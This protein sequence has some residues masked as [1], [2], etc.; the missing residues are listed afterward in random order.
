MSIGEIPLSKSAL[1]EAILEG[2]PASTQ[3]HRCD[4]YFVP[5]GKRAEVLEA[6]GRMPLAAAFRFL[7]VISSL[8]LRSD[9]SQ[10]PF[11]PLF[12]MRGARSAVLDEISDEQIAVVDE[13]AS[14]VSDPE[15]RARLA[16]I[17][18]I[19]KRN[20]Q[21][22][23]T[24][25]SAY[26]DSGKRILADPYESHA[27]VR[28]ERALQ[29]AAELGKQQSP[30]ES[31][32]QVVEEIASSTDHHDLIISRCLDLTLQYG[33]RDSEKFAQIAESR[34]TSPNASDKPIWQRRFWELGA[35]FY[36]RAGKKDDANRSRIEIA[37]TF[38]I[39]AAQAIKRESSPAY[40]VAATFLQNAI[41]AYRQVPGTEG[42]RERVHLTLLEY[43]MKAIKEIPTFRSGPVDMSDTAEHA[44]KMVRGKPLTVA[45]RILALSGETIHVAKLRADAEEEIDRCPL[46]FLF[47]A[48]TMSGTGKVVAKQGTMSSTSDEDRESLVLRQM[49]WHASHIH[50][51]LTV[52]GQIEPMRY[53]ILDEQFVRYED[54]LPFVAYNPLIPAGREHFY[55]YGLHAGLHGR[56]FEALH[57]LI[58]QFENSVR[59]LLS[60]HGII[61]SSL[62]ARGLQKEFDLNA[63]LYEPK[64][65][66]LFGEDTVFE[67]RGL[68]VEQASSNFRNQLAHGMLEYGAFFTETAVYIWWLILRLCVLGTLPPPVTDRSAG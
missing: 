66:E 4:E 24:A 58:P 50:R 62:D 28:F 51:P 54:F 14:D 8:R 36:G 17:V 42:E 40:L 3:Q 61:A 68:L 64:L 53:Q 21:L 47:P 11:E 43:Q 12:A 6:D 39:E 37:K 30:F 33:K 52:V 29:I 55:L 45:L 31:A 26:L 46:A 38:E 25:V 13:C 19:R 10:Q 15:L 5:F 18:W 59:C 20:H 44:K 22:A 48:S 63:M 49:L 27:I 34:A 41:Q 67:L 60:D 1:M 7:G 57:I 23:R 35:R 32:L 16:D 65:T 56:F 9:V 2:V